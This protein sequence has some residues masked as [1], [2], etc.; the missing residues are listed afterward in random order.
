MR[1]DTK[2]MKSRISKRKLQLAVLALAVASATTVLGVSL[3]GA[4]KGG[5]F[6][7]G[8][9]GAPATGSDADGGQFNDPRDVAGNQETGQVFVVDRRNHRVQRF[10]AAGNFELAWGGD[11]SESDGSGDGGAVFEICGAAPDCRAGIEGARGG[12][13]KDPHG[14]AIHPDTGDI[15][16]TDT[17]NR[18]V[19]HFSF[20]DNG[21]PGDPSDDPPVF[22]GAWGS[23]TIPLGGSGDDP[24]PNERQV[25]DINFSLSV[26]D[27]TVTGTFT[28]AFDGQVTAPI[29]WPPT[30]EA[31]LGALEGLPNIDPGDVTVTEPVTIPINLPTR[32][33]VRWEVEF[34]AAY[35]DTNVVSL[36]MNKSGIDLDGFME[37]TVTASPEGNSNYEVCTVASE[38]QAG[39]AGQSAGAFANAGPAAIDVSKDGSAATGKVVVADPGNRRIQ[40]LSIDGA[41]NRAFA[42]GVETGAAEFEICTI[43]STCQAGVSSSFTSGGFGNGSPTMLA[44]D[45][46]GIVYA[47]VTNSP[48]RLTRFDSTVAGD[49]GAAAAAM[50]LSPPL[51]GPLRGGL[52][53]GLEVDPVSDNLLVLSDDSAETVVQEID[54]DAGPPAEIDVHMEASPADQPVNGLGL[55]NSSAGDELFVSSNGGVI[56]HRVLVLTDEGAGPF[57]MAIGPVSDLGS[58][59]VTFNGTVDAKGPTVFAV[60]HNFQYSVDGGETWVTVPPTE[61]PFSDADSHAVDDTVS[62][63]EANTAYLVRLIGSRAFNGGLNQVSAPLAFQTL[64][65]PPTVET[66]QSTLR[67]DT[68]ATLIG[69]LNPEGSPTEWRFEWGT[70]EKSYGQSTPI[71]VASGGQ[72]RVVSAEITGLEPDTT[73]HYRLVADN[74]E[75]TEPGSSIVHGDDRTVTTRATVLDTSDRAYE[76]V[77]PPF[78]T[79]RNLSPPDG[80]PRTNMNPGM[81]SLDGES[82]AWKTAFFPLTDDVDASLTG[83]GRISE[84]TA[85]GWVDHTVNTL[86]INTKTSVPVNLRF[87]S[88]ASSADFR[89]LAVGL[90]AGVDVEASE[91]YNGN[92]LDVPHEGS[93]YL[94]FYTRRDGTGFDGYNA[95]LANTDTQYCL[96]LGNEVGCSDA[97][98]STDHDHA[99]L[100]D[101]GTA[102]ARWGGYRGLGEDP[103]T[104]GDD[105]P[106]DEQ[107]IP[108]TGGFD[109][110]E[111]GEAAYLQR[112]SDPDDL[113]TAPKQLINECSGAGTAATQIPNRQ[114]AGPSTT[115]GTRAC[116]E[117]NVVSPRGAQVGSPG[118]GVQTALANDGNRVFFVA[119]DPGAR[120]AV[121]TCTTETGTATSCP[122][123][124]YVRQHG[125]GGEEFV[126]WI[127]RS[128]S[129]AVGDGSYQGP[130]I[131][132]QRMAQLDRGAV[133]QRASR[134]GRYIY[135]RTDMPLVPDD[136]NGFDP[137]DPEPQPQTSITTGSAQEAST[138]L[139]RYEMPADRAADPGQGKLLRISGGPG[140][141]A[142]PDA[143]TG[144][145]RFISEDGSRVYFITHSPIDGADNDP[146]QGG[147]TTPGSGG[148]ARN[149]YLFDDNEDGAE[150]WKFVARIP[151]GSISA[152]ATGG[153]TMDRL[154]NS[155]FVGPDNT[156]RGNCFRGTR[157]ASQIIFMTEAALTDDD[158]DEAGDIVLYAAADDELIRVSAADGPAAEPYPCDLNFQGS[159]PPAVLATCNAHMDEEGGF[160]GGWINE[161][162]GVGEGQRGWNGLAYMNVAENPDGTVSVFFMSRS[163]L[164][165]EDTNGDYT[166][167][168]EWRE[169]ELSLIT[170][171]NED[172]DAW[173]TGNSTDGRDVF[174]FTSQRIDPREIDD[175]DLDYYDARR[176]GGF[177]YTP[178][179]VP[180][181][182]LALACESEATPA[183]QAPVGATLAPSGGGNVAQARGRRTC[184]KAKLRQGKRCVRKAALARKRCRKV[185]GR[186][187]RRCL[188]KQMRRLTKA[189][190]RQ[191]RAGNRKQRSAR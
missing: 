187:K 98:Y 124:L 31:M 68:T 114:F 12:L 117:G 84:R 17:G 118:G 38:C 174:F 163:Q 19:Q 88:R 52:L 57:E 102:M 165:P 138:D 8:V 100:N 146:P 34:S 171:G 58:H 104:P 158:G 168:Y 45:A 141:D 183:P 143:G 36:G 73:Y 170:P 134:D 109:G 65:V 2:T 106:S 185:R 160:W 122:P 35:A 97:G 107:Q 37:P 74:G 79:T 50:L 129:E 62:G 91:Q 116:A 178:P 191:R 48:A 82:F 83:D 95:W 43:A 22:E 108:G 151:T 133:F 6:F 101:E 190:Q 145:V 9:V 150:R 14:V 180:C 157:D 77:S 135:F 113:P 80:R 26:T 128:R 184:S 139:Y 126:R 90:Y 29:S 7:L 137:E 166:D 147:A 161:L 56:E 127:S 152:C 189:Q 28:L 149:L 60:S 70:D 11:V 40:E 49:D 120:N 176:G 18:R 32:Y 72:S 3:A 164:V 175:D 30:G 63:L 169:G 162:V 186:A 112:A 51:E 10:D 159:G 130:P 75:E 71:V 121:T 132:D 136:P 41:F 110:G 153:M 20:E 89:T 99:L 24:G 61:G 140:G 125:P 67:T 115:I 179:P 46:D 5:D 55:L 144:A 87:S 66:R 21:T 15:Y 111:G 33:R 154:F 142:D 69:R 188:T 85:G 181:D 53:G 105:D 23:N 93:G 25:F 96:P 177:P 94:S 182:V 39:L 64:A 172:R 4:S 81:P 76:M 103:A 59:E 1:R 156:G 131:A 173:F 44:V 13:F 47:N 92:E 16:V 42:S 86:G 78:K 167:A 155:G 27:Q 119:P 123:Q 148:A 54:T